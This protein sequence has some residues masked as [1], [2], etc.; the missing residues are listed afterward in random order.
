[1]IRNRAANWPGRITPGP[2]IGGASPTQGRSASRRMFQA[3]GLAPVSPA[4]CGGDSPPPCRSW[5]RELRYL[6]M[7]VSVY[8]TDQSASGS[9]TRIPGAA[10]R[11]SCGFRADAEAA[12]Q[13]IAQRRGRP[14]AAP[15]D[16]D[17][18]KE[19]SAPT[20]SAPRV[21]SGDPPSPANWSNPTANGSE[22]LAH[23]TNSS[24]GS[25]TFDWIALG[26]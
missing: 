6:E 21:R 3:S 16:Q 4:T 9:R 2:L 24:G 14:K 10:R 8:F 17:H 25:F 23:T 13:R 7:P 12:E 22:A 18:P 20:C 11:R 1:M 26:Y 15:P 19:N 5:M